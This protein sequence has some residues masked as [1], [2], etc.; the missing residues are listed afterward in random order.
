MMDLHPVQGV[1]ALYP[2][3]T[4]IDSKFLVDLCKINSSEKPKCWMDKWMDEYYQ[5]KNVNRKNF[6]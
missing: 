4:G 5:L 1:P 2:K 6:V 3:S